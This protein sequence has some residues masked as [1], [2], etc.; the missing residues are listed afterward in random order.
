MSVIIEVKNLTKI[1]GQKDNSVT[2]LEGVNL[3]I[4]EGEFWVLVGSSGCGKTTLVNTIAGFE[5]LHMDKYITWRI[6]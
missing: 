5:G 3:T 2:A 6:C 1:F 4:K